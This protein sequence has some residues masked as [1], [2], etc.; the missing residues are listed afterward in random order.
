MSVV[1]NTSAPE[2][3]L[4]K[5]CNSICYHA[6]REAVATGELMVV[7]AHVPGATN[8]SDILTK[9]FPGAGTTLRFPGG[10]S[11]EAATEE[12]KRVLPTGLHSPLRYGRK[13][14]VFRGAFAS[15][16]VCYSLGKWANLCVEGQSI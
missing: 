10:I 15:R 14:V 1:R 2:S 3:V 11:R 8:T 4:R 9:P 13:S 5:K 7:V 12:V 16:K 6:V